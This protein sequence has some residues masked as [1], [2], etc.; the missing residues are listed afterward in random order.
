[1]PDSDLALGFQR[2][3]ATIVASRDRQNQ[4]FWTWEEVVETLL[5]HHMFSSEN[6]FF[7]KQKKTK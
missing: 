4:F 6:Y 1:M 2:P 3:I 5:D 7:L